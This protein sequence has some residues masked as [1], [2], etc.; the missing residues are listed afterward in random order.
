[1]CQRHL[2]FANADDKRARLPQAFLDHQASEEMAFARTAP[3]ERAFVARQLKSFAMSTLSIPRAGSSSGR[4]ITPTNV[5][6]ASA[7]DRK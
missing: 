4:E 5:G 2:L 1:L 7:R 3:T 6:V